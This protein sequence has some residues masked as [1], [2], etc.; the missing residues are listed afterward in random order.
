MSGYILVDVK[1]KKVL[2]ICS[3]ISLFLFILGIIIGYF[4]GKGNVPPEPKNRGNDIVAA[5]RSACSMTTL[6][7]PAGRRYF[8]RYLERHANKHACVNSAEECL[9]FG[10]PRHYIAYHLNGQ[11]I[12]IDGKLDDKAWLEVSS[13]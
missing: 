9:D 4:S 11:D 12:V 2:A 6:Q 1:T 5:I 7:T 3:A 8:Q 13:L 10:L